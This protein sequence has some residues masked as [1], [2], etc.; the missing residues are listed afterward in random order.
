MPSQRGETWRFQVRDPEAEQVFLVRYS[1]QGM[2]AWTPMAPLGGGVWEVVVHLDPGQYRFGYFRCEGTA[3]F[4]GGTFGLCA[5]RVAGPDPRVDV[6]PLPP[7]AADTDMTRAA[8][9]DEHQSGS[10]HGPSANTL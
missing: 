7:V 1:E 4:N 3:Y 10:T 9:P 6:A 8:M 5:E 2:S